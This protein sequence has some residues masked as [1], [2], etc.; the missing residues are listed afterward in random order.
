MRILGHTEIKEEEFHSSC[1]SCCSDT[2]VLKHLRIGNVCG[3]VCDLR[4]EV[5]PFSSVADQ[6]FIP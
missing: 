5:L 3:N 1:S 2:S 6:V 4:V